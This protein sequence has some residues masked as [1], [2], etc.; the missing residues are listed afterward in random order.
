MLLIIQIF[1]QVAALDHI[2]FKDG[3]EP[4]VKLNQITK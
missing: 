4:D 1:C 3:R 2:I